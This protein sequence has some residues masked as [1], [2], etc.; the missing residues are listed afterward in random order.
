MRYTY[1]ELN[2]LINVNDSKQDV[3]DEI[4]A[5]DAQ[6]RI[7]AQ[8]RA[9]NVVNPTGGEYSYYSGKNRLKSVADNMGGTADERNMS[10]TANFVYDSVGNLTYDKYLQG[11]DSKNALVHFYCRTVVYCALRN[12]KGMEILYDWRGMPI[13]FIQTQQPTGSS[14]DTLFRLLMKYD[15]TGR[16]I[17]KTVMHKVAGAADWDTAQVTHYTG[18]GTEVRE[19]Y[20]GPAKQTK[21][22][23]NMPQ[24]LGRYGIEG[25]ENPDMGSGVGYIPNTKFEWYLKNHL[26][27]TMLVYGTQADANPAHSDIGT[28]LAAY[29]YR[30]FGEMIELTPPPTGK[31]TENFTGKERDDEIALDYFGARYLDPMLGMWIS[32]DPK[33]QHQNPYLYAGNNPVMRIDPDGN[34]DGNAA[35]LSLFMNDAFKPQMQTAFDTGVNAGATALVVSAAATITTLS[36]GALA[37]ACGGG[38]LA[39]GVAYGGNLFTRAFGYIKEVGEIVTL[40]MA[41]ITNQ[42]IKI[43]ENVEKNIIAPHY[44]KISTG[45]D[46]IGGAISGPGPYVNK[47]EGIAAF[48]RGL[49]DDVMRNIESQERNEIFE[50][51]KI[52]LDE[53][54]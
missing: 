10:D 31:V 18:I 1:D 25:A 23:V 49:V 39:Q 44:D 42:S 33:R 24:S 22:V 43:L 3:F 5:Y 48:A 6:G 47:W 26:G 29:D 19:N 17:S 51:D 27:S 28:T 13:E 45:L 9:G 53:N 36:W 2:R 37:G 30:A 8:R 16:R 7:T 52:Q 41:P 11:E 32:V 12:S 21:V 34:L 40:G 35:G 46:I 15:G 50:S 4:F 38:M 54:K 14:S 20:A